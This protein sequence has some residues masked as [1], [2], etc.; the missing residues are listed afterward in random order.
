MIFNGKPAGD[1]DGSN[2]GGEGI[3]WRCVDFWIMRFFD[4]VRPRHLLLQNMGGFLERGL[5]LKK[6]GPVLLHS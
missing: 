5:D 2:L 1:V 6:F 4:Q 3:A